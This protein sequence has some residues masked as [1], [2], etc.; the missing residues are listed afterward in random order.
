MD[1]TAIPRWL[2]LD[3]LMNDGVGV[4]FMGGY[5]PARRQKVNSGILIERTIAEHLAQ[6]PGPEFGR[7]L[8]IPSM[9]LSTSG[10][11]KHVVHT[12]AFQRDRFDDFGLRSVRQAQSHLDFAL[13]FIRARKIGFIDDE[14]LSDLHNTRF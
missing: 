7:V 11:R 4:A 14:H 12:P 3:P 1:R 10:G 2:I 8:G 6:S 5:L 13:E 9:R